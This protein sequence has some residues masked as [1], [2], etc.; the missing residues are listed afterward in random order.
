MR[1]PSRAENRAF[2][3]RDRPLASELNVFDNLLNLK[4]MKSGAVGQV[5]VWLRG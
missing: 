3:G 1:R 2:Y 4:P 5:L